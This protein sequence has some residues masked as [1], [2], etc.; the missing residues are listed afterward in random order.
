MHDNFSI[1]IV[2]DDIIICEDM[3]SS[4][5]QLGFKRVDSVTSGEAALEK[6]TREKPDLVMMDIVLRGQ[7]NGIETSEILKR[8]FDLSVIFLSAHTDPDT[9]KRTDAVQ[10][11]GYLSKPFHALELKE[12]VE[13][14]LQKHK[15]ALKDS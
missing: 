15:E 5:K 1:L 9:K 2:E 6:V 13:H 7:L 4:L 11:Y 10:P 8:D 14:A 12:A 3:K